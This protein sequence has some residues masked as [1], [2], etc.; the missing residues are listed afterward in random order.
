MYLLVLLHDNSFIPEGLF[1][2]FAAPNYT[3]Y[4]HVYGRTLPQNHAGVVFCMLG[5]KS[6]LKLGL[7]CLF[8]PLF[9]SIY[10]FI[11]DYKGN[12]IW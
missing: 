2:D 6:M 7:L 10:S 11:N 4:K 1:I 5:T 3:Y 12:I 9:T 8:I